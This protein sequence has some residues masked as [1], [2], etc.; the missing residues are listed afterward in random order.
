MNALKLP[1]TFDVSVIKSEIAQF[2]K[3]DFYDIYNP[4][5]AIETLW[6]KE[7]IVPIG[8]PHEPVK[9]FANDSLKK[10]PYLLSIF[11]LFE[12]PVE[13]FRIHSL[14]P[15]ASISPHNDTGFSFEYGKV[16]LHVPIQTNDNV[17]II[18]EREQIKMR[19]GECWY[20]NFDKLHEVHNRGNQ[21]RVHLIIDCMVNDWLKEVFNCK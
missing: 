19:E 14:D 17:D 3:K 21:T 1:Y 5:V 18:L 4:S 20:C 7:F 12:C 16:R 11:E 6:S 8:G 9:F 15:G 2:T 13:T 10:C